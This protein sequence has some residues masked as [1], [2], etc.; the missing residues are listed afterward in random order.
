MP[1]SPYSPINQHINLDL[2]IAEYDGSE[3]IDFHSNGFKIR[4]AD[5][6][7]N[8]SGQDLIYIAFAAAPFKYARAN[9][10]R[11]GTAAGT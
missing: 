2:G 4:T 7:V 8:V 5:V 11:S 6:G 10:N 3:D 9:H 1:P